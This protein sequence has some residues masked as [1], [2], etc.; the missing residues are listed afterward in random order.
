MH[1]NEVLGRQLLIYMAQYLCSEYILGNQ[2]IQTLINTTRIH[3]LASMNPDGYEVAAAEVADNYDPELSNQEVNIVNGGEQQKRQTTIIRS[4][5]FSVSLR[6]VGGG[7]KY[8]VGQIINKV[9]PPQK[10]SKLDTK[11]TEQRP[12][13]SPS[14]PIYYRLWQVDYSFAGHFIWYTLP[15]L[16]WLP[17]CLQNYL[18]SWWKRFNEMQKM[19]LRDVIMSV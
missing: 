10:Y 14:N 8:S 5:S 18:I 16:V 19:L 9:F 3:I 7:V 17:F 13:M 4:H 6:S 1:G 12:D 11:Y 15:A 2:R